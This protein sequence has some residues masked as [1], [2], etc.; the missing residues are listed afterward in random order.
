MAKNHNLI[1]VGAVC[2]C[3]VNKFLSIA[4]SKKKETN[5]I[6]E[7][8]S[9]VSLLVALLKIQRRVYLLYRAIFMFQI[10][11][12]KLAV[13]QELLYIPPFVLSF[14]VSSDNLYRKG[15]ESFFNLFEHEFRQ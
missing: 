5:K 7:T 15:M 10:H 2:V 9:G 14:C 4:P 1:F 3:I 11:T 6:G 8:A 12:P 13:D